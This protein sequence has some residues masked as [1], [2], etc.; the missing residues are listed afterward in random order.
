[1]N[2]QPKFQD[3]T[4]CDNADEEALNELCLFAGAGGGLLG[5]ILHGWRSVCYV[6]KDPY[7][8]RVL[9]ARIAEGYLCDAPIWDDITTFDGRPWAGLVDVITAGF[10]CQPF[11]VAGKRKGADDSRNMWPETIRVIREVRPRYALCENV[12]GLIGGDHGYFGR[13]L[14]DLSQSGYDVRWRIISAADVGAPHLRKRLWILAHSRE[15]RWRG[16]D[17][18]DAR[19][20]DGTLQV[21][22][23]R[24]GDQQASMADAE[25]LNGEWAESERDSAGRSEE[26]DRNGSPVISNTEGKGLQECV[27]EREEEQPRSECDSPV[28]NS[29]C[30]AA[31]LEEY[32]GRGQGREH[33]RT[34]ESEM[35]RQRHREV[36]SEGIGAGRQWWDADPADA[37]DATESQMGRVAHG[38]P[39][40]VGQ[41]RALGN[42]QVPGVARVAWHLLTGGAG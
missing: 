17:Y 34:S 12:P 33:T 2:D 41:L 16:W 4:I 6:E 32:Q 28:P 19:R 24:S 39:D 29:E 9:K 23:S 8:I 30:S 10:P 25:S 31:R 36:S 3:K 5:S 1:M 14:D 27:R 11:S 15:F 21:K 26:E 38:V 22:R 7:C 40:R 35:V 18:G 37:E 42:A 20:Q 13:I